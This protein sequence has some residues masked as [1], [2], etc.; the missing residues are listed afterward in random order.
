MLLAGAA[1]V[2]ASAKAP[3]VRTGR[4]TGLVTGL[5]RPLKGACVFA[6]ELDFQFYDTQTSRTGRYTLGSLP[7]GTYYVTFDACAA[8]PRNWLQQWYKG[9]NSPSFSV[10]EAPHGAVRLR[11]KAGK[12]LSGI[13][14]RL[15]L[16]GSI[17]GVVTSASSGT[18][19]RRICVEASDGK[20]EEFDIEY[21]PRGGRYSLKALFPGRYRVS[22]GCGWQDG[23]SN[24]AP[25]WWRFSATLAHARLV[26]ITGARNVRNIDG[27]LGPGAIITGT[28]RSTNASGPPLAG[29]CVSAVSS[30]PRIDSALVFT[31]D[32][33]TYRLTGLATARYKVMFDPDCDGTNDFQPQNVTVNTTAGTTTSG[34]NVNLQPTS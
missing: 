5:G 12:T 20:P 28:V 22:F 10:L 27:K 16:G 30:N 32:D 4:I 13:N 21:T 34:V 25:Q 9:V 17:S 31:A 23:T 2:S 33:G 19:L 15:K 18:G 11:V 1:A 14:G 8:A 29:V 26:R 3:Q 7:P 24:F 6:T